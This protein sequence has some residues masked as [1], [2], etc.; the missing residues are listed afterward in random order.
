MMFNSEFPKIKHIK[1]SN[2]FFVIVSK[3]N[4]SKNGKY[5]SAVI[6][7]KYVFVS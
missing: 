4:S 5:S 1:N 7:E 3:Q 6:L 2:L